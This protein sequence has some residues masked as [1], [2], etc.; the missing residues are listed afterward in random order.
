M[1]ASQRASRHARLAQVRGILHDMQC[2]QG[3]SCSSRD[4]HARRTQHERARRIVDGGVRE[5]IE[6]LHEALCHPHCE[7]SHRPAPEHPKVRE[8]AARMGLSG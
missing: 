3:A 5:L 8:L 7:D 4:D 1:T 2:T 6:V